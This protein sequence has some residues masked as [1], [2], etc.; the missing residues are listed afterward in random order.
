MARVT[1]ED[2][3]DKVTNRF[4]LVLLAARRAR[5][6]SSG[7]PMSIE[8]D[9]DKILSSR[10][11]KLPSGA[12]PRRTSKRT[13]FTPCR[14][15]LRLMSLSKRLHRQRQAGTMPEVSCQTNR[16]RRL[17]STASRRKSFCEGLGRA[18]RQIQKSENVKGTKAFCTICVHARTR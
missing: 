7:A 13:S 6:V 4:E 9:N 3:I 2:C 10:R 18:F 12:F 14:S 1:V 8:R 5:P 15:R 17:R 16:D 11:A